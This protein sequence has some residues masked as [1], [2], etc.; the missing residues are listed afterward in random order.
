MW[1]NGQCLWLTSTEQVATTAQTTR[2]SPRA[3]LPAPV[4]QHYA[5]PAA[6]PGPA[7][8]HSAWQAYARTAADSHDWRPRSRNTALWFCAAT[9]VAGFGV[10]WG[11]LASHEWLSGYTWL[12][13][14]EVEDRIRHPTP[15]RRKLL[16]LMM[17]ERQAQGQHGQQAEQQQQP[18]GEPD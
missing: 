17:Q 3:R 13:P 16:R 12:T 8:A 18:R 9:L 1:G 5:T 7:S 6:G 10:F 4:V 11:A 15:R 2:L 14:A